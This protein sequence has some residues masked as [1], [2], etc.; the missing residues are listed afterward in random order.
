MHDYPII[1][2]AAL[3]A[4]VFGLFSKLAEWSPIKAGSTP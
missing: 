2:F 3:L 4:Y 1:I